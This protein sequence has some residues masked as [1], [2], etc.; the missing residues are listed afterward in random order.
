MCSG[1]GVPRYFSRACAS[2]VVY[3]LLGQRESE[4]A[5]EARVSCVEV[6]WRELV[7]EV[8]EEAEEAVVERGR[9]R[10]RAFSRKVILILL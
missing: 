3:T 7:E 1:F 10:F 4:F 8:V 9:K 5:T 2:A 6:W